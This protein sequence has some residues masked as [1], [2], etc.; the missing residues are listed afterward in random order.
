MKTYYPVLLVLL[1]LYAISINFY[2]ISAFP[3]ETPVPGEL[4]KNK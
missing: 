1:V 2:E 3:Q 4:S